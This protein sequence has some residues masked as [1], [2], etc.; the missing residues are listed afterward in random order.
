MTIKKGTYVKHGSGVS[1]FAVTGNIRKDGR[2]LVN[3]GS[4]KI[5]MLYIHLEVK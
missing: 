1:G 3:T 4:D 5:W 2:I